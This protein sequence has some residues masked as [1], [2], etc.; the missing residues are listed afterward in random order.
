MVMVAVLSMACVGCVEVRGFSAAAGEE[1]YTINAPQ[2]VLPGEAATP[3]DPPDGPADR[4]IGRPWY[5]SRNDAHLSHRRGAQMPTVT[6]LLIR[7]YDRQSS[8]SGRI[9]NHHRRTVDSYEYGSIA[10]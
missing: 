3:A 6:D 10:D 7:T 4:P 2:A 8:T 5:A 1:T 9:Y